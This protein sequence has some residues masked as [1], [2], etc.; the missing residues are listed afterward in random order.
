MY[1]IKLQ[2]KYDFL[3]SKGSA[4]DL[5]MLKFTELLPVKERVTTPG[6]IPF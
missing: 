2:G 4:T 6:E 5:V 3:D 1:F